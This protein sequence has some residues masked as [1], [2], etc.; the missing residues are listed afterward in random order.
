MYENIIKRANASLLEQPKMPFKEIQP[1]FL[2]KEGA[3]DGIQNDQEIKKLDTVDTGS[4]TK[5]LSYAKIAVILGYMRTGSS[6]TGSTI[7]QYPGTF[8]LFEP[9]RDIWEAFWIQYRTPKDGILSHTNGT[10]RCV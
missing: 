10:T 2:Q 1:E 3:Q 9:I 4:A 8:Y 5:V 7:S 6:F